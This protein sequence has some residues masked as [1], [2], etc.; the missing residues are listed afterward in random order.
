ML[1]KKT[2]K[3]FTLIANSLMPTTY[4]IKSC[5]KREPS[6]KNHFVINFNHFYVYFIFTYYFLKYIQAIKIY[7]FNSNLYN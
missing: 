1:R 4:F 5:K 6:T 2:C 7:I 3:M